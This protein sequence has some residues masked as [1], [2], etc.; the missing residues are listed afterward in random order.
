MIDQAI[1]RFDLAGYVRERGA[2][3]AQAGEWLMYC[4]TC[5]KE[6]LTVNTKKKTWHCWVCQKFDTT[7]TGL[8]TRRKAIAGAGGLLDLLQLLEHCDRKRA[9]QLVLA[10]STLTAQDLVAI[11]A[12][13][14]TSFVTSYH[15]DVVR[16]APPSNWRL[17]EAPLPYMTYRGITL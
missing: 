12:T 11:G 2:V 5:G 1:E 7:V 15:Q 14:F 6:K 3:E 13:E 8:H 9:I 17:I 16:I 10:S 4:P